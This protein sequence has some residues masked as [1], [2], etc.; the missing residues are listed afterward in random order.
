MA[1]TS[2]FIP[3]ETGKYFT[4]ASMFLLVLV[5]KHKVFPVGILMALALLPSSFIDLSGQTNLSHSIFNL[6][7]PLSLAIGIAALY[8][9]KLDRN[10][11][12]NIL[13]LALYPILSASAF[14]FLKTPDIET[15]E[16]TL[17]SQSVTTAGHS[18]NQVS[19]ILGFGALLS[20]YS[21]INHLKF[22]G[23]RILDLIIALV[24]IFQGLVTFSRGGILIAALAIGIYIILTLFSKKISNKRKTKYIIQISF[25]VIAIGLLFL[26][27]NK[28]TDGTLL[29]RYQGETEGTLLYDKEKNLA[30]LTTGRSV[31]F[32]Q[33][34][35]LWSQ[36]IFLGVGVG[37]SMYMRSSFGDHYVSAHLE[38][39]R[40]LA[41][42]GLLGLL[43]FMMLLYIGYL[44]WINNSKQTDQRALLFILFLVAIG[45]T[46]HAGMR[47]YITPLLVSLSV[48]KV[49]S[50]LPIG[51][52]N[53]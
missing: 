19:T 37:A 35:K 48:L 21:W 3:Y 4:L 25:G 31:I 51:K 15:I 33:D 39:S 28:L 22:S 14:L 32:L 41:E 45:T 27:A 2:P 17:H 49:Q 44:T 6:L 16:F 23:N 10:E 9:A 18:S 1:R 47:T 43:Y 52:S 12:N 38:L 24:L 46:F 50:S 53:I 11:I 8:Y 13:R 34:L 26:Q 7:G 40:L 20:V 29:L 36:H 5:A 42:H 30:H